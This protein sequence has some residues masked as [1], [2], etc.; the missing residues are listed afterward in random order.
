MASLKLRPKRG[1]DGLTELRVGTRADFDDG[2]R[3]IV[4]LEGLEIGILRHDGVF[5]AFENRCAHQGGPVCE[6]SILGKVEA[7]LGEDRRVVGERFSEE[8]LHLICPW[9][10]WEYD[11]RT[12]ECAADRSVGL[13]R[14]EVIER[15][16]E[17]YVR[18]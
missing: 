1:T 14:F 2:A 6:G 11:L 15:G 12:G 9:H 3:R 5:H 7:V 17:I 8:E 10:G 18:V 13:R 16:E 4:H